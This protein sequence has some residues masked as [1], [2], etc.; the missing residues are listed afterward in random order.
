MKTEFGHELVPVN[1]ILSERTSWKLH[2]DRF[3]ILER[4]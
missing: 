2:L 1:K 3:E 4:D